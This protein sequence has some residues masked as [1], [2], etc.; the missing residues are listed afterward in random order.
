MMFVRDEPLPSLF[1]Q[2]YGNAHFG[3]KDSH[4]GMTIRQL[5]AFFFAE[6]SAD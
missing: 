5:L 3:L 6:R 1:A 4:K 2:S